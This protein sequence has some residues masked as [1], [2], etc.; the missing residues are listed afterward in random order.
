MKTT[1]F[2]IIFRSV[3]LRMRNVSDKSGR[4]NQNINF[5]LS[6]FFPK[7]CAIYEIIL[8]SIVE[9]DRPQMKM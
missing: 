1:P 4:E 3:F 7:N 5:M 6:N 8:K 2:T 9:P